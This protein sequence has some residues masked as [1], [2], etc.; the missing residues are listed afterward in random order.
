MNLSA[1]VDGRGVAAVSTRTTIVGD[2]AQTGRGE[3]RRDHCRVLR[4]REGAVA[5]AQ[6]ILDALGETEPVIVIGSSFGGAVAESYIVGHPENVAGAVFV[7]ADV[8]D[9]FELEPLW[10]PGDG[11]CAPALRAADAS[12][13][14]EKID[15]CTLAEWNYDRRSNEPAVP[16]IYLA[17]EKYSWRGVS[18]E[19]DAQVD[20]VRRAFAERWVPGEFRW[21]DSGH[22]IEVDAPAEIANA[23]REVAASG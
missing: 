2:G 12:E 13:S 10:P 11:A 19:Y 15:N 18:P 22:V 7:D 9:L 1:G 4:R 20:D 14:L 23:V 5:D 3:G 16:L 8:P 6:G 21:V 17:A